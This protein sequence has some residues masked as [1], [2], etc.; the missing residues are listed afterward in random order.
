MRRS[1][2]IITKDPYEAAKLAGLHYSSPEGV[3]L[4]RRK[5]GKGF[6]YVDQERRTVRDRKILRRIRS[7]VIPPAWTDV[8]ISADEASHIQA[9]GRDARGRKQYRYHPL[10]RQIRDQHKFERLMAFGEALPS[11]RKVVEADIALPGMPRRKLLAIIT[12]L[13]ETTCI[14][15][16]NEEYV[17]ENNSFGLTTLKNK[18]VSIMGHELRFRFR[19]KSGQLHDIALR[20]S[21]L[22]RL[23]RRCQCIPGYEL[24]RY[25]D[26]DGSPASIDSAAVNEYLRE[27]LN[28]DFTAKDFRT[29]VGSWT[30]ASALYERG[31]AT[32]DTAA[33]H[34][35]AE[36][37]KQVAE[38]LGNRPATCRAYYIHPVV[39]SSYE[40]GSLF[41]IYGEAIKSAAPVDTLKPEECALLTLLKRIPQ[42]IEQPP[43]KIRRRT[44]ARVRKIPVSEPALQAVLA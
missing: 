32:S 8:W 30:A 35:I 9:V 16:G 27:A 31:P 6:A 33:K 23:I 18:H 36:V 28:G 26:E 1:I 34:T 37:V 38:K 20:D 40:D 41:D 19:G 17:R 3:G 39:F 10:Y 43:R 29:W 11:L 7:L 4:R 12:R 24:F 5:F 15:V 25:I 42:P 13:L 2:K 14:R 22:A 44:H 21:R